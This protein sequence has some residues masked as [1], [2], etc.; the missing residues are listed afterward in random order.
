[1]WKD[2]SPLWFYVHGGESQC[3]PQLSSMLY[4]PGDFIR[5]AQKFLGKPHIAYG[6]CLPDIG[7][8]DVP[9]TV[10]LFLYHI[11]CIAILFCILPEH[12]RIS[13]FPVSEREI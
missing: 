6:E 3:T 2:L 5:I 9:V 7:T 11:H 12:L 10:L 1:S 4:N 13:A 8:A